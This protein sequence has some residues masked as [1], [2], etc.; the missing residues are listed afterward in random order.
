MG[1]QTPFFKFSTVKILCPTGIPGC[2]LPQPVLKMWYKI[3]RVEGGH[4]LPVSKSMTELVISQ[5]KGR[6]FFSRE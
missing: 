6:Q 4:T 2:R 5:L 3:S 1:F